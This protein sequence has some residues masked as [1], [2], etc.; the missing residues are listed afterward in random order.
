MLTKTHIH[1]I[2]AS[3]ASATLA[4]SMVPVITHVDARTME[5]VQRIRTRA[6]DDTLHGA[7]P[8]DA[9]AADPL[10]R[11]AQMLQDRIFRRFNVRPPIPDLRDAILQRRALMSTLVTVRFASAQGDAAEHPDWLISPSHD[12]SLVR[13]TLRQ[14]SATFSLNEERLR[15]YVLREPLPTLPSPTHATAEL[16]EPDAYGVRRVTLAG[17]PSD[18]YMLDR[19]QLATQVIDGFGEGDRNISFPVQP[20]AGLITYTSTDGATRDLQLLG[21]GVSSYTTSTANRVWNVQ[22]ALDERLDGVV[23][24]AGSTFSF[25]STLG[26]PITNGKGWKD[27]LGIFEGWDLRPTPGGGICQAATTFYRSLLTTGLPIVKRKNH[28]LFVHYYV[29]G[30]VGLDA[31]IFPGAQDLTFVNDTGNDIVVHA[32]WDENKHAYVA[33]YGVPDG[34]TS[35]VMGPYFSATAPATLTVNNRALRSNEV[36]WVRTVRRADG[37]TSSETIVSSYRS[38]PRSVVA[39]HATASALS[40]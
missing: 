13:F 39:E 38:I 36:G 10:D 33:L 18:G 23:V 25:N 35:E 12:P 22:K 4:L 2:A 16:G 11:T 40:Y 37:T 32:W 29:E 31:T 3:V 28:S 24:P 15:A 14:N 21:M 7:A 30:G 34:R 17:K 20:I 1:V 26:A 27:A 9:P 19:T 6:S 5:D 8:T